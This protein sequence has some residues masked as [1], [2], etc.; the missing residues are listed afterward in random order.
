MEQYAIYCS[1]EQTKRAYELG[2]P[3]EEVCTCESP[4]EYYVREGLFIVAPT[5]EQM[6]RWSR[7]K[8][9]FILESQPNIYDIVVEENEIY[10]F[11]KIDEAQDI[12]AA[13]DT[14]LDYLEKGGNK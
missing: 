4:H 2:A 7:E 1:E 11:T 10:V 3:I 6:C 8:G 14:A 13:I 5:A 9:I 12:P